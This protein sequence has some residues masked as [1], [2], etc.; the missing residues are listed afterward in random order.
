MSKRTF[1]PETNVSDCLAEQRI[2]SIGVAA[3]CSYVIHNGEVE[4]AL[5]QIV[6]NVNQASHIFKTSL[7]LKLQISGIQIEQVCG[8]GPKKVWNRACAES[9]T[10]KDRLD[11]F[12]I[13]RNSLHDDLGLWELFSE[14]STSNMLGLAWSGAICD[15]QSNEIQTTSA[16]IT[17]SGIDEWITLAH[18]VKIF[19]I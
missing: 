4:N 8:G 14:C 6:S 17:T 18:E 9:Y 13:W 11:D 12:S 7:N 19:L 15:T 5:S 16:G 3:D 2:L 10:I 1:L